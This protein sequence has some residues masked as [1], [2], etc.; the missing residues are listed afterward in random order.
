ME[1]YGVFLMF[2]WHAIFCLYSSVS[3]QC[4]FSYVHNMAQ[5]YLRPDQLQSAGVFCDGKNHKYSLRCQLPMVM[6]TDLLP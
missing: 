2:G 6:R 3:T 5:K 4:Q 1:I